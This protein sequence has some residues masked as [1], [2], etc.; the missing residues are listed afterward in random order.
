MARESCLHCF[1][2]QALCICKAVVPFEIEPLIV[3]LVHPREFMKTVGTVRIVKLSLRDSILLRGFGKDFD[4]DPLVQSL[5]ESPDHHAMVLFPGEDSLNLSAAPAEI[6]D[7]HLPKNKRLVIFVIDGTWSA[8]KNM[9]RESRVLSRLP[10]LSFEVSAK[11]VYEFRKQP[12]AYSLSTVEAVS[13]LIENLKVLG[14]CTPKPI[15]GHQQMI[16][17]FKK[18]IATQLEF[19]SHPKHRE[20]KRF[21]RGRPF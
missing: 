13:V 6:L 10:K 2:I 21:R 3:L 1:R 17:T 5:I 19:E 9:I 4:Q 15:H 8:A 16:E 18:L 14:L 12:N 20:G 7:Q 11:S